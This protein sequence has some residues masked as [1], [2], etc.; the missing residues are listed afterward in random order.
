ML[1]E[2]T[3][4]VEVATPRVLITQ[5]V[6]GSSDYVASPGDTLHYEISFR[7]LSDQ[8]LENLSLISTLEGRSLDFATLN[9]S[10]G[11]VGQGDTSILWDTIPQL[12]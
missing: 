1:N 6:N 9:A 8:S 10:Q 11:R 3:R 5:K 2:S 12:K 7:N 4:A